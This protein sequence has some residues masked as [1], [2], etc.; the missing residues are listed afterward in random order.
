MNNKKFMNA[1]LFSA[2]LLS[3]GM[4]SSC[5]DYDDDIDSL[6]NR[7]DA[8]ETTL[9]NLQK[10]IQEGKWVTSFAANS[11]NTGYI[12]TLSDGSTLEIKNGEKGANGTAGTNGTSW[13]I[14]ETTKNWIKVDADGT[15]TDMKICAEGQK[16]DKGEDGKSPYIE[17]GRWMIWNA[18]EEKFVDGGSA[19][20]TASY[21]V[22]YDAYW[23]LNVVVA[24]KEGNATDEFHKIIL[25]KT[26]DITSLEVY[27]F[28]AET[29]ELSEP[30]VTLSLGK[31]EQSAEVIFNGKK[32][33][34]GEILSL[35]CPTQRQT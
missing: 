27:A 9:A 35:K 24:D 11:S 25:P 19:V 8:V 13:E 12:L 30:K 34:K 3:T 28:D 20:G 23:E 29:G 16:G 26:A 1:L 21:V 4:M 31:H 7:V 10:Q 5:N 2:A 6:N 32:Y 15:R 33:A 17:A 18:E 14:D 22:D